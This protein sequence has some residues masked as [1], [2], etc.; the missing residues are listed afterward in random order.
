VNAAVSVRYHQDFPGILLDRQHHHGSPAPHCSPFCEKDLREASR[1]FDQVG[2]IVSVG[3]SLTTSSADEEMERVIK[4]QQE[5]QAPLTRLVVE[6]GFLSEDDLL[7]VL[8]D[9]F[10][11][12]L[13]SLKDEPLTPLPLEFDSSVAEFLRAARIVPVK[14]DGR[15][16]LVATND[17]LELYRLHALE[18][19]AAAGEPVVGDC[20]EDTVVD[21]SPAADE[22][23]DVG[24]VVTYHICTDPGTVEI[25]G[26][27]VGSTEE[28]A[29]H[30]EQLLAE[31]AKE[32]A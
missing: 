11:L 14:M 26:G 9:F 30:A 16:L 18:L 6:L 24:S 21:Q 32:K 19:A 28:A 5:Q 29:T 22:Q 12:P 7:P 4:L 17:P 10:N 2:G 8:R 20:E 3:G 23:A 13:Y 25:P 31:A 15:E 1:L 27:L